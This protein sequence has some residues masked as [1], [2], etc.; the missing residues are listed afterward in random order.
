[1]EYTFDRL[2]SIGLQGVGKDSDCTGGV[3]V[4]PSTRRKQTFSDHNDMEDPVIGTLFGLVL[5][6]QHD[7]ITLIAFFHPLRS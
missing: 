2:Y 3:E 7:D 1:M 5:M 4:F 6:Q